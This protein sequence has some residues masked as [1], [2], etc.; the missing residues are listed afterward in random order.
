[1]SNKH[2]ARFAI[3]TAIACVGAYVLGYLTGGMGI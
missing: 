1:M 2:V 3:L